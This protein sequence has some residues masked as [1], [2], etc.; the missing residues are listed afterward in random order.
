MFTKASENLG[1]VRI[2][3]MPIR[4][5]VRSLNA[6][7]EKNRIE[8]GRYDKIPRD[9]RLC[10]LCNCNKIEDETH[11][12]LDCPSYSSIRDSFFLK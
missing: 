12:L 8:T 1:V 7:D 9:E 6:R 10:S 11:L 4:A 2:R 3:P 5:Q